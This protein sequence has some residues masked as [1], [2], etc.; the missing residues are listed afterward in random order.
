MIETSTIRA[1]FPILGRLVNGKPIVYL[2]SAATSQK[3]QVVIEALEDYYRRYNANIHRGIY[4]IAEEAT[5]AYEQ[6]RGKVA[7]F[8]GAPD[9][10]EVIF[11][12]NTTEAINLVAYAWGRAHVGPGDEIVL[13]EMEHHSNLVPWIL[14]TEQAGAALKHIPFDGDGRLDMEVA[15]RLITDRTKLV[16]VVHV[17]NVLGTINPVAQIADLA[18]ARGALVLVDGA[19]SVPHLSVKVPDLG[20][21]FLAFSS[22]KMLG[23]TGVGALWARREI[24]EAMP[25]FL[26]GGEMI[27]QVHL[28]RATYNEIPW[29]FEAGTPNIADAITWGTA[30]G[31]LEGVGMPIIREHEIEITEYAIERLTEAPDLQLYGPRDARSKGGVVAFNLDDV[32]SHD[33]AAVL[34]ADGVCVRVGHH[35]CQPMMRKLNVAGTVR[36]SFYLYNSRE[37]I[38]QLVNGLG[39]VR[40]IF[41]SGR[42]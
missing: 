25:P 12:R 9:P 34:D 36:A 41:G 21:D 35:C 14:L 13:T 23:P 10:A 1:D 18:H 30:I 39:R 5:A 2:D 40:E 42:A 4:S 6:A 15:E 37:D 11:T 19:Q 28:D 38:D 17:S 16:G 20:C 29:K 31:Y 7:R 22:H 32:H 24:L 33:V 26:G 3:P 27:A 8:I